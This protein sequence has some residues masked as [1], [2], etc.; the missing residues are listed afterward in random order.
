MTFEK[1]RKGNPLKLVIDQHFHTAHSIEKFYNNDE[2]VEVFMKDSGETVQR[3]KRAKI[4]CAKRNWDE[5]AERGYMTEIEYKF[6][7]QIDNLVSFEN[8]DHKAIS[9]YFV[10]WRLR[11]MVHLERLSNALLHG[12]QGEDLTKEQQET[13]EKIGCDYVNENGEMPARQLTG[14]QIQIGVMGLMETTFSGMKW[15]LLKA[16]KGQFL[17]SDSYKNLCILPVSPKYVFAGNLSDKTLDYNE[18]ALVNKQSIES[19]TKFYFAK[20]L[21]NCPVA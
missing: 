4:F 14:G 6:H 11:Y 18:V 1:T 10:L 2:K 5:R 3:H 12:V 9:E 20:S 17:C 16:R 8:R 15:G 7:A 19:A 21:R 13:L